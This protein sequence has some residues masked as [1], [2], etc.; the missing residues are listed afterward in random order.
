MAGLGPTAQ[1]RGVGGLGVLAL[2]R[3]GLVLLAGRVTRHHRADPARAAGAAGEPRAERCV[4]AARVVTTLPAWEVDLAWPARPSCACPRDRPDRS[5]AG[6]VGDPGVRAGPGRAGARPLHG[7]GGTSDGPFGTPGVP[8][9]GHGRGTGRSPVVVGSRAGAWAPVPR[10]RPPSSSTPTT[11]RTGRRAP[12]PTA[13]STSWSTS[14]P[15]GR[16]LLLVSRFLPLRWRPGTGCGPSP[17]TRLR[18]GQAGRPWSGSIVAVHPRSGMF[19]EEFVRLARAVLSDAAARRTG[20]LGL[21]LQ[22]HRWRPPAGLPSLRRV[23][24]VCALRCGGGLRRGRGSAA[25]P[26]LW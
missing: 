2:G 25:L 1:P 5:R 14:A 6:V 23:G 24:P 4:A 17:P 13:R 21:G 15:G 9:R 8:D 22:P 10:L 20:P 3:T 18:N 11:R 16:A 12:R 19:S 26:A 7:L